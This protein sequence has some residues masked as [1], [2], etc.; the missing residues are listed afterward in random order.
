MFKFLKEKLKKAVKKFGKGAEEKAAEKVVE[1][2]K[3]GEV[4]VKVESESAPVEVR[5]RDRKAEKKSEKVE[6]K[7]DVRKGVFSRV[8]ERVGSVRLSEA[9]FEKLFW[10][11]ES[12]LLEN[13]AALS[14]IE[15]IHDSLAAELVGKA[16]KRGKVEEVVKENLR[17]ALEEVLDV[18]KVDLVK[19][20]K[21]C[22]R[23][24]RSCLVLFLGFNGVGKSLSVGLKGICCVGHQHW[25]LVVHMGLFKLRA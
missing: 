1:S 15:K 13:N 11:I 18:P 3:A 5:K 21:E 25:A 14:V 20:V 6:K 9:E 2:E 17:G 10:E 8:K 19:M 23:D 12:V 16:V 24:G 22:K 7:E 4:S